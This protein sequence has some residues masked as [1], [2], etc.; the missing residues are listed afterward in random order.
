[1]QPSDP[2][3]SSLNRKTGEE[4]RNKENMETKTSYGQTILKEYMLEIVRTTPVENYRPDWLYGMELDLFWPELGLAVEFQGDQHYL[5]VFGVDAMRSQQFRDARKK[6]ICWENGV[7]LIEVEAI[8]LEYT[9]LNRRLKVAF[10]RIAGG[11]WRDLRNPN[12]RKHR[13]RELNKK[14][15]AYRM[16]LKENFGAPTAYRK[17]P[18]RK[19]AKRQWLQDHG[20]P[21]MPRPVC[22]LARREEKNEAGMTTIE[23]MKA[24]PAPGG[25]TIT[26]DSIKLLQTVNGGFRSATFRALGFQH[27]PPR[28][29]MRKL[30]GVVVPVETWEAAVRSA[31]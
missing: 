22:K 21:V 11:R 30:V 7:T 29:W 20:H 19:A 23:E 31:A 24:N 18:T 9:N 25:Y 2:R 10:R 17:G 8:H 15:I 3:H 13:L 4:G 5:P 28:R 1:M 27:G 16:T 12:C 26:K 14:A 6:K